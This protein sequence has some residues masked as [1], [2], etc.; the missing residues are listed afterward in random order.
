M[1]RIERTK[2]N[3]GYEN[4]EKEDI[5]LDQII[6]AS[7]D[8]LVKIEKTD[9]EFMKTVPKKDLSPLFGTKDIFSVKN[10][11]TALKIQAEKERKKAEKVEKAAKKQ[12]EEQAQTNDQNAEKQAEEEAIKQVADLDPKFVRSAIKY[13]GQFKHWQKE[14][15]H[16]VYYNEHNFYFDM[17]TEEK[18]AINKN[19]N[20]DFN[21]FYKAVR[22]AAIKIKKEIEK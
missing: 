18:H 5:T 3:N 15:M 1:K 16:R 19:N 8:T 21:G 11:K 7:N 9:K 12:A 10:I 17:K 4:I 6:A 22:E 13:L 2:T 14:D 20:I